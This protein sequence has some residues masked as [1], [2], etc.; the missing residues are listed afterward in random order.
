MSKVKVK[1]TLVSVASSWLISILFHINRM[2]WQWADET[3]VE[4]MGTL[5]DIRWTTK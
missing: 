1:G 2:A 3:L 4:I 5:A